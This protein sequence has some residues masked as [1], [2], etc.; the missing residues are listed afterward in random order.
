M[1]LIDIAAEAAIK[2]LVIAACIAGVFW[3]LP[4]SKRDDTDPPDGRSGM[5]LHVDHATG[6]QYLSIAMGSLSP[7]LDGQG[8]HMGCKP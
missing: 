2:A 3:L 8:R 4:P 1:R 5:R 6:C 7:R